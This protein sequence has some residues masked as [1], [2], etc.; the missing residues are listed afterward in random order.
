MCL[1]FSW[2]K[3]GWG[4]E[5]CDKPKGSQSICEDRALQDGRPSPTPRS[6]TAT[7]LDGKDGSEGCLP[8]DPYSSRPSTPHFPM[9]REDLH[10]SMPTPWSLSSTQGV[11]KTAETSG[12]LLET[13]WLSPHNIL[14]RHA[15]ATPG[16]ELTTTGD[17]THLPIVGELGV[18]GKPEKIHTDTNP[19]ARIS[20][21]PS[22]LSNNETLDS[23]REIKEDPTGC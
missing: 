15:N 14:R 6:L 19:G 23:L 4:S 16:Q 18:N 5:T 3:K 1:K 11:H 20:G 22:V 21:L 10:V 12:R 7:R 13:K 9:G 8:S 17:P 2:W